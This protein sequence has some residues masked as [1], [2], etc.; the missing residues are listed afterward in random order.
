MPETPLWK[1]IAYGALILTIGAIGLWAYT[2][3]VWYAGPTLAWKHGDKDYELLAPRMLGIALLAPYF[4]WVIGRSLADLPWPQRVLSVFLRVLFVALVALGLSRLART[5]TTSKICTV[6]VVD[7]SESVPDA[8]IAD[9]RADIQHALDE[10][11]EDAM[12]RVITFSQRPQVV[13]MDDLTR[14]AP[15]LKRHDVIAAEESDKPLPPGKKRGMDAATDIGSAL[16]LA[17][18]LYPAGYLR[19]AVIYS[20]GVSEAFNAQE[21][22]YGNERLL[23]DAGALSGESAPAMCEGLLQKVRAFAGSAPQS[24]DIAIVALKT[25]APLKGAPGKDAFA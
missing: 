3:Y 1:R 21:E 19:R 16:Q 13:P 14:T 25:E 8:A 4:L 10:K 20:D 6:Y 15:E 18:G 5:A 11:P 7:V 22:C 12:I 24:D 17:Y 23:A 2:K 9:A